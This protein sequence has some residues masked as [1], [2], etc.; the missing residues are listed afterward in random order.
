M[1]YVF[2]MDLEKYTKELDERRNIALP[3]NHEKTLLFCVD[4]FIELAQKAI[5]DKGFF[6]VALSGGSTPKAILKLLVTPENIKRVDFSKILFFFGD[7]RSVSPDNNDSN[8]KM[9]MDNALSFLKIPEE[10]IHRMVVES[11]AEKHALDYE[12]LIIENVPNAQFDLITL[13]MGDDGHTASLFPH[14]KAL[15]EEN[16]LVVVNKVPQKS[17]TRMTLTYKCINQAHNIC[18][19]VLGE[20]KSIILQNVLNGPYQ[21]LEHPSQKIGTKNSKALWIADDLAAKL[22]D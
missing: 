5:D 3:G 10:H 18:F 11:D 6:T 14:T 2:K 4:Y 15:S 9:A 17:T 7:E 21:P 16:R 20:K 8:Y 19:F 13:G 22:I 1:D 12:K